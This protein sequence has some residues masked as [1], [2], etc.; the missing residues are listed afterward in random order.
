MPS[1][2]QKP[3]P[4]EVAAYA[5]SLGYQNFDAEHFVD[6]HIARG[7]LMRPGIPMRDWRAAARTWQRNRRRWDAERAAVA[8]NGGGYSPADEAAIADYARQAAHIIAHK[9]GYDVGSLYK[10]VNDALGKAAC[11]EVRRRAM[12]QAAALRRAGKG[13]VDAHIR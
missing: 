8:G 2:M 7:W 6:H 13:R 12:D 4:D 1:A 9:R 11:D 3:T 10:K 5:A